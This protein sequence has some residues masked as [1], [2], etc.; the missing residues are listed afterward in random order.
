M[1]WI[2][3]S[4]P[5]GLPRP[6]RAYLAR[7]F[8][9]RAR[10]AFRSIVSG[11]MVATFPRIRDILRTLPRPAQASRF[12]YDALRVGLRSARL[13]PHMKRA[14]LVFSCMGSLPWLFACLAGCGRP[15][16]A[17]EC[18]ELVE[19]MARLQAAS[20]FPGRPERVEE[21]VQ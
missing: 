3:G 11:E 14:A 8:G 19:R 2:E 20:A 12:W 5:E 18:H 17:D 10:L 9:D 1:A 16:T 21:E 6:S 13:E 15:A 7:S 4:M